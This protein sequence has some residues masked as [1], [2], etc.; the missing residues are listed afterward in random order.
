MSDEDLYGAKHRP[1]TKI[2]ATQMKLQE[3]D[4]TSFIQL[5]VYALLPVPKT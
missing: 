1:V 4:K 3:L 5:I 2:I